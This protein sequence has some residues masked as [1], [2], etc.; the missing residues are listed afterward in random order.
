V[1]ID[2]AGIVRDMHVGYSPAL[3]ESLNASINRLLKENPVETAKLD[4]P[5]K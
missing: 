5:A 1:I 2:Q 4:E 3:R